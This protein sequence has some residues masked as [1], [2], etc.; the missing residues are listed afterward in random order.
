[1][2]DLPGVDVGQQIATVC[3]RADHIVR[4]RVAEPAVFAAGLDDL[5]LVGVDQSIADR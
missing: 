3:F 5:S 4:A 1:V 2:V